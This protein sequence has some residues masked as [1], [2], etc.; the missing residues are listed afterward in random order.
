MNQTPNGFFA[1]NP[2]YTQQ[3]HLLS[4]TP[5]DRGTIFKF[6]TFDWIV[7]GVVFLPDLLGRERIQIQGMTVSPM[8]DGS[9]ILGNRHFTTVTVDGNWLTYTPTQYI[10][11]DC[12]Q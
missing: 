8:G 11:P 1:S 9:F 10:L 7:D 12:R 3:A 4:K 2:P 6:D 5:A